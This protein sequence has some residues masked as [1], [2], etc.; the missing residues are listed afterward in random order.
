[1]N[2]YEVRIALNG[3]RGNTAVIRMYAENSY[4]CQQLAAAQYGQAN[5]IYHR[6]ITPP[7]QWEDR[8]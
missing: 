6:D 8:N 3:D 5:V 1:M 4:E 2:L 7:E